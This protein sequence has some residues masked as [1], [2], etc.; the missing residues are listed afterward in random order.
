MSIDFATILQGV[1]DP[2]VPGPAQRAAV[3]RVLSS[4]GHTEPFVRDG[5]GW[6]WEASESVPVEVVLRDGQ[7][8]VVNAERQDREE[9]L[10]NSGEE[11]IAVGTTRATLPDA[12]WKEIKK[13]L[14]A[15]GLR[16]MAQPVVSLEYMKRDRRVLVAGAVAEALRVS[17]KDARVVGSFLPARRRS[18]R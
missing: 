15:P 13:V 4:L 11:A 8:T 7:I 2:D 10:R 16:V 14:T 9:H 1:V 3:Q 5:S 18:L 12:S 6:K 17:R